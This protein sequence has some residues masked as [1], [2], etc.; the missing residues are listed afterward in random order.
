MISVFI[1]S[2]AQEKLKIATVRYFLIFQLTC[3]A[4]STV[5]KL[6]CNCD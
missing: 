4:V 5:I 3:S 1:G 2:D 6:Q